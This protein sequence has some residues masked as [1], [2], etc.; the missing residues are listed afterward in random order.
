MSTTLAPTLVGVVTVSCVD[1][2]TDTP[3]PAAPPNV[4]VAPLSKF[5]PLM[6]TVV[7]EFSRP[8]DGLTG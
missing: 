5:S 1:P 7:A 8:T 4:T 6:V 3:V 2:V